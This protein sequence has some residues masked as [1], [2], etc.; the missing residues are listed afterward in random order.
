MNITSRIAMDIFEKALKK[1]GLKCKGGN[2]DH[3]LYFE[4]DDGEAYKLWFQYGV[5]KFCCTTSE[6]YKE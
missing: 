2:P 4:D 5:V 1:Q 6:E 3:I